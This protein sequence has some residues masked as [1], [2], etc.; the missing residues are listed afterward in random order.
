MQ[1]ISSTGSKTAS[2]HDATVPPSCLTV[3]TVFLWLNA[4]PLLLQNY[5]WSL[6]STPQKRWQFG[7]FSRQQATPPNN[8][9]LHTFVWTE[10]LGIYSCLAMAPI[11][12]PDCVNLPSSFSDLHW[13]LWIFLLCSV[14]VTSMNAVKHRSHQ[15]WITMINNRKSRNLGLGE[16]ENNLEHI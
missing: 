1:C 14:Y 10:Y 13:A 15:L 3:D 2:E 9:Y 4:S 5:L 12:V 16:F 6:Q 7:S 11:D 8:L